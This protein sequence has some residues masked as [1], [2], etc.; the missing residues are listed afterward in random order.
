MGFSP[1]AQFDKVSYGEGVPVL[2]SR[3]TNISPNSTSSRPDVA[4]ATLISREEF[5]GA[6][7]QGQL[8]ELL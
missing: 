4:Q 8:L 6:W 2:R 7:A 1:V 5:I 3:Q